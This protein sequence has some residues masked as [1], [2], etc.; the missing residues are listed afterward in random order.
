MKSPYDLLLGHQRPYHDDKSRFKAWIAA[1]QIGKSF[2]SAAEPV[3]N[4]YKY[5]LRG[6]KID[7]VT[8]S[9]GERQALE[10]LDKAKR[11][12]EVFKMS[13]ADIRVERDGGSEAR[14]KAATILWR[15]GSRVIALPANP[16]TA[17]GYSAN[18]TL[19]EF[20]F[21]EDPDAIWRAVYPI[22]TNP[23]K[24]ELKMR[25]MSSPNGQGNKFHP[26][27]YTH[28]TLPTIYSV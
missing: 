9:A 23:L 19:D 4:C 12:T 1:R 11:W 21:H 18:V 2:T 3:G 27:S 8:L 7:W 28:L 5:D 26:V 6:E 17:R 16:N 24:G 22:I 15:N 14:L 25:V 10:W 13:I 20:A